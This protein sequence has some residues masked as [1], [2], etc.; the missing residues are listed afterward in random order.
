MPAADRRLLDLSATDTVDSIVAQIKGQPSPLVILLGDYD[1]LSGPNRQV[2]IQPGH[3]SDGYRLGSG[4]PRQWC[5]LRS[6]CSGRASGSRPR[7]SAEAV[8]N[9]ASWCRST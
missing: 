1:A 2:S 3:R 9:C 4:D 7:T 8:W 5:E 6:R